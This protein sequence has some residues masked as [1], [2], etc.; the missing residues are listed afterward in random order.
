M[1]CPFNDPCGRYLGLLGDIDQLQ[2]E[3]ERL[4]GRLEDG[5]VITDMVG[6]LEAENER[7]RSALCQIRISSDWYEATK[8]ACAALKGEGGA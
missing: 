8:I 6:E 1:Q 3:I 7:L 2:R 4:R 5:P